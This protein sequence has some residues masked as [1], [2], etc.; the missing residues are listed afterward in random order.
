MTDEDDFNATVTPIF[1]EQVGPYTYRSPVVAFIDPNTAMNLSPGELFLM[2]TAETVE[3]YNLTF[4]GFLTFSVH[5][6]TGEPLENLA[7][8]VNIGG[9]TIEFTAFELYIAPVMYINAMY[10]GTQLS[11]LVGGFEGK[12]RLFA[13]KRRGHS[14]SNV[15]NVYPFASTPNRNQHHALGTRSQH[16]RASSS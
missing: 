1:A 5:N 10:N 6:E 3:K 4:S 15:S 12:D 8:F 2:T 9:N 7:L 13:E 16:Q 14:H 11:E